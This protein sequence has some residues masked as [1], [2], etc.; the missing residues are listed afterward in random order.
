MTFD[1]SPTN[2]ASSA[3]SVTC[4]RIADPNQSSDNA[5]GVDNFTTTNTAIAGGVE[6]G[7]LCGGTFFLRDLAGNVTVRTAPYKK[8]ADFGTALAPGKPLKGAYVVQLV[9]AAVTLTPGHSLMH[10]FEIGVR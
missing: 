9:F 5:G 8:A 4:A 3:V 1:V 7:L 6:A 10:S 2:T